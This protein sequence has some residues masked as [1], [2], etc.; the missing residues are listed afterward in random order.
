MDLSE[1]EKFEAPVKV[2]KLSEA[3]RIGHKMIAEEREVFLYCG[4]GCAIGAAWVAS[5]R[6][7]KEWDQSPLNIFERLSLVGREFG[8]PQ[9]VLVNISCRHRAGEPRLMIADKLEAQGY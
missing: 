9:D 3:I 2:L 6:T 4:R 1:I 8:V 7:E 5:G